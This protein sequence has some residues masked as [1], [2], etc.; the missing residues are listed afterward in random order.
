MAL[1]VS[2]SRPIACF[3]LQPCRD[4]RFVYAGKQTIAMKSKLSSLLLLSALCSCPLLFAGANAPIAFHGSL[5][6]TAAISDTYNYLGDTKDSL[7]LNVTELTLN[8]SY[9]FQSG[10]RA[11]AQVYAYQLEGYNDIMI[12]FANL[13]WQQN[14]KFGVRLGY[15]KTP[16]GFYNE[17]M[18]LDTVRP[19]AFLPV[20]AYPKGFRPIANNYLGLGTYGTLST[21]QAGSLEYNLFVGTKDKVNG[22]TNMLRSQSSGGIIHIDEVTFREVYGGSLIWNTP[23]E[24]LRAVVTCGVYPKLKIKGH[25]FTSAEMAYQPSDNRMAPQMVGIAKWDTYLANTPG[26]M[27]VD[28]VTWHGGLEYTWKNFVF[29]TEYASTNNDIFTLSAVTGPSP[30][31][32]KTKAD[33]YYVMAS[34]QATPK[35]S[36]GA[37]YGEDF[38]N[39]ND[40]SGKTLLTV[41]AHTAY[42]KDLALGGSYNLTDWWQIKLENHFFSG[43]SIIHNN[44][45]WNGSPSLWAKNWNYFV[46]KS[47]ISF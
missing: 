27:T 34:W 17:V 44:A 8:G 4:R 25:V 46:V 5:S 7:D 10:L 14:E 42:T 3:T 1:M 40:R 22:D 32:V 35:F 24:G 30:V 26:S 29:V 13:D 9:R 19:M 11:M 43:T 23:V 33:N 18:D 36:V 31:E 37:Y 20:M 45:N 41:P 39:K 15:T 6:A 21:G 2:P 38:A 28:Y 12:D 16:S 47:T